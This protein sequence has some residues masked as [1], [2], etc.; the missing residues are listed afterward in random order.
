MR[1]WR[2]P[3]LITIG[4]TA[5]IL[6]IGFQTAASGAGPTATTKTAA[7]LRAEPNTTSTVLALLPAGTPVE[8]TCWARGEATYG[9][10][11]YGSMWLHAERGGWVHSFLLTPIDVDRCGPRVVTEPPS[12]A[13][14]DCDHA[15]ATDLDGIG[16]E[17]DD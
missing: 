10:D 14:V 4:A 11:K 5:A 6:L 3:S 9:A 15:I 2:T 12:G 8:V 17:W 7:N 16:C 1:G 13:Y